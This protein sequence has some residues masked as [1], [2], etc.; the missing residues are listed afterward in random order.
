MRS[1]TLALLAVATAGCATPSAQLRVHDAAYAAGDSLQGSLV[2]QSTFYELHHGVLC[3][4]YLERQ[5]GDAWA[6]APEADRACILPLLVTAPGAT[7]VFSYLLDAALPG[8]QYRLRF[9]VSRGRFRLF[10]VGV[11][12]TGDTKLLASDPFTLRAER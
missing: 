11:G 7:V 12:G 9:E 8:G 6:R 10:G 1:L 5:Q 4:A 3:F 2:N